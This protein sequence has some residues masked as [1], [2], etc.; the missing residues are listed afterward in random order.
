MNFYLTPE[1]NMYIIMGATENRSSEDIKKEEIF[2]KYI[3]EFDTFFN[4]KYP[5]G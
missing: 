2:L 3:R 4:K 5:L 1:N